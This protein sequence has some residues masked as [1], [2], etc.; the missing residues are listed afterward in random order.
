MPI[1]PASRWR[2]WLPLI[3]FVLLVIVCWRGLRL[4]PH[5][6]PS[7][8]IDK[9]A[10]AFLLPNLLDPKQNIA[11][12]A[13]YG[14]VTLVNVWASWCL[15]CEQEHPL[16]MDIARQ[17]N[18]SLMGWDYKDKRNLAMQVLRDKGNPFDSI[19]YDA[20]GMSAINWGIYGTP[21]TFIVDKQGIIRYKHVGALTTQVW[22]Q[23]MLPLI[24]QW[25]HG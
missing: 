5:I 7:P 10:P 6:V 14:H 2:H 23:E 19:I 17:K 20:A 4:N 11:Q 24:T 3:F 1:N 18:I 16:L 21:E 15:A 8:L 9:P 25:E 12:N 13:F 22:Q